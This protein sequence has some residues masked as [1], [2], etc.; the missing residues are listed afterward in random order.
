MPK[1]QNK[2]PLN[3]FKIKQDVLFLRKA[4]ENQMTPLQ[5]L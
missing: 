2:P 1:I 3:P 4:Q 5:I